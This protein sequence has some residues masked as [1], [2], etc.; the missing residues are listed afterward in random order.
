MNGDE[1]TTCPGCKGLGHVEGFYHSE[2]FEC[3][4]CGGL[5][6]VRAKRVCKKCGHFLTTCI[7]LDHTLAAEVHERVNAWRWKL[8]TK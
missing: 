8:W 3:G 5:G 1:L 7:C 4:C 2:R 6:K